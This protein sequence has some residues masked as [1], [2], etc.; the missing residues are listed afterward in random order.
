MGLT[1]DE[2]AGRVDDAGLLHALPVLRLAQVLNLSRGTQE[3]SWLF[4]FAQAWGLGWGLGGTQAASR[5]RCS[6]CGKETGAASFV[7]C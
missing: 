2:E 4:L 3:N 6:T 5:R 7:I 1:G